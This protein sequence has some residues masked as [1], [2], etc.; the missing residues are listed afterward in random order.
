[1]AWQPPVRF[2][3]WPPT[4]VNRI[5]PAKIRLR[6][7]SLRSGQRRLR[8]IG[9]RAEH[10]IPREVCDHDVGNRVQSKV[11]LLKTPRDGE[12]G[13]ADNGESCGRDDG[14]INHVRRVQ[15]RR[16]LERLVRLGD[17]LND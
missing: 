1:M 2:E 4:D 16:S 5:S 13:Q 14:H 9:E 7:R 8:W 15:R 6:D 3:P 10:T 12:V 11:H 17:A